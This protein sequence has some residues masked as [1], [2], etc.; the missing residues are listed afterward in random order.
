MPKWNIPSPTLA[1]FE[2]NT[3]WIQIE[4]SWNVLESLI[5]TKQRSPYWTSGLLSASS[6]HNRERVWCKLHSIT[7]QLN[8]TLVFFPSFLFFSPPQCSAVFWVER[9]YNPNVRSIAHVNMQVS[10]YCCLAMYI[11]SAERKLC[12]VFW[13][14]VETATICSQR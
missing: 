8:K 13:C 10:V 2:P 11:W 1:V 5:I 12:V 9:M 7:T 4:W 3:H 14:K 6:S